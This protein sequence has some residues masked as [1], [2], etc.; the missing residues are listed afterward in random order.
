MVPNNT[1]KL[2]ISQRH[3]RDKQGHHKD[4]GDGWNESKEYQ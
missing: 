2:Q 4:V 1:G 3:R